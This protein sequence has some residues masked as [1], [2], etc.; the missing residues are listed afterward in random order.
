MKNRIRK[1]TLISLAWLLLIFTFSGCTAT[2]ATT[3]TEASTFASLASTDAES[4]TAASQDGPVSDTG[5]ITVSVT[6]ECRDAVHYGYQAAVNVAPSGLIYDGDV[7]LEENASVIDALNATKLVVATQESEYGT[8]V[9]SISSLAQGDCGSSSGWTFTVNGEFP[10][11]SADEVTL[12]D[13]DEVD[14]TMYCVEGE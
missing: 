11:V 13:G 7:D 6:V 5:T 1:L 10:T 2:S 14:W 9:T 4:E 8:Y 3:E 12:M